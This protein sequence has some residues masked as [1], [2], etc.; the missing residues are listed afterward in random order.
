MLWCSVM[1]FNGYEYKKSRY[2]GEEDSAMSM[3]FEDDGENG[4]DSSN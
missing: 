2:L 4:Y 3:R 1:N